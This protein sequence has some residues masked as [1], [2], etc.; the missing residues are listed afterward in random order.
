MTITTGRP[1]TT[2]AMPTPM[3]T[4][5]LHDFRT[6]LR[7]DLEEAARQRQAQL[8]AL[9]PFDGDLVAQAHRAS[10]ERILE[11]ITAALGRMDSGTF[12]R[13]GHCG[14]PILEERL[15]LRPWTTHCTGCAGR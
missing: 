1:L 11:E 6:R 3:P 15:A 2:S 8:N 10:V 7:A 13:C 14:I 4:P 9:P 5:T 12:G